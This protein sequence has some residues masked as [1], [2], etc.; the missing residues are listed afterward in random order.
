M[1]RGNCDYIFLQPIYNATQRQT[2]WDLEAAF[3]DR[4]DFSI[5]MD[6]VIV[7]ENLEGNSAADP[8]KKVQ[9]M[10]CADFED[11]SVAQEKVRLISFSSISVRANMHLSAT[12][13][14]RTTQN[15]RTLGGIV[16]TC[17]FPSR[18]A[19]AAHKRDY[20]TNGTLRQG[21]CSQTYHS[22]QEP[23]HQQQNAVCDRNSN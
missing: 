18:D 15:Q 21:G 10:V 1:I 11:S 7:R 19:Q 13:N 20:R 6:Q 5:L 12:G 9:I 4:N 17:G 14:D 16:G 8:K 23:I 22:W 2:L 3:L